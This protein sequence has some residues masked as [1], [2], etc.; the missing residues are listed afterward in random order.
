[1]NDC[2]MQGCNAPEAECLGLCKQLNAPEIVLHKKAS[3]L[4]NQVGGAHYKDLVI[5]PVEYIHSN[6]IPFIEGSCI[7]YL[8][9]WREKGGVQDLQKVKH[10]ID[11]L[12][13]LE[14]PVSQR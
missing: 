7:K 3:A 13:E 8:T 14:T 6:N 12:I 11:L 9:R 1:M 4:E 2:A 10:F 5:Q